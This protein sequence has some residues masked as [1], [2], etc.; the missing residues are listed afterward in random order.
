[1]RSYSDL[2]DPSIKRLIDE[3]LKNFN[4]FPT[5]S[6]VGE[7]RALTKTKGSL[8]IRFEDDKHIISGVLVS[9]A[10]GIGIRAFSDRERDLV[11][12]D[13]IAFLK[14]SCE[15]APFD[16]VYNCRTCV[17]AFTE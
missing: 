17:F 11:L 15:I 10:N 4:M 13:K 12:A 5:L 14:L 7:P 9:N 6:T 3:I 8:A 1:M 2:E 16:V